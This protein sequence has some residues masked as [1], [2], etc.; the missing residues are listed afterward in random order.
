MLMNTGKLNN[1]HPQLDQS[2]A[3]F[4]CLAAAQIS[5]V[6]DMELFTYLVSNGLNRGHY[7]FTVLDLYHMHDLEHAARDPA[8]LKRTLLDRRR[9]LVASGAKLWSGGARW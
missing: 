5:S 8:G 4:L 9:K 7:L 1:F 2:S 6:A 3:S